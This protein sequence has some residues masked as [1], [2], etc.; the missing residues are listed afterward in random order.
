MAS[1]QL[2]RGYTRISNELIEAVCNRITN[3][4]WVRILFWTMRLTYGWGRKE[5][6]SNYGAYATKLNLTKDTIKGA[7]LEMH[8]KRILNF[9]STTKERFVVAVNKNY[10]KWKV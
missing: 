7:L 6:D 5:T 10:D 3:S 2:E 9:V 4:T 1:P 8:D